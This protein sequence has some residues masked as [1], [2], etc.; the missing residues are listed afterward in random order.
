MAFR[1]N[2]VTGQ[3]VYRVCSAVP[4]LAVTHLFV[5]IG[6][7]ALTCVRVDIN[8]S[9]SARRKLSIRVYPSTQARSGKDSFRSVLYQDLVIMPHST[10]PHLRC[11]INI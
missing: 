10:L 8:P 9:L 1:W 5:S 3:H 7:T 11:V 2:S 4:V 6:V